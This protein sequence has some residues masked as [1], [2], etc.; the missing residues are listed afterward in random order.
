VRGPAHPKTN[1]RRTLD[2]LFAALLALPALGALL[3]ALPETPMPPGEAYQLGGLPLLAML[4]GS[5]LAGY[6][7]LLAARACSNPE[8]L[9]RTFASSPVAH[10]PEP[11]RDGRLGPDG[12]PPPVLPIL[13]SYFAL[14]SG[15]GGLV[16]GPR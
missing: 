9:L 1:A 2:A 16:E 6:A 5:A 14:Q 12:T 7:G 13:T 11:A 3:T 8:A 10:P 4:S 15:L